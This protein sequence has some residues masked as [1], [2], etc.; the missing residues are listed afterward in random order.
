M[1]TRRHEVSAPDRSV[2]GGVAVVVLVAVLAGTGCSSGDDTASGTSTTTT[3]PSSPSDL[4]APTS[5]DEAAA[6]LADVERRLR[7]DDTPDDE[8]PA[9]GWTQ[10]AAYRTVLDHPGWAATVVE[11]VPDDLALVVLAN[12]RAGEQLGDLGAPQPSL[13]DWRISAPRPPATLLG[14]YRDAEARSGIPW[15]YLAAIHLVESRMGRIQGTS[16]AGAQ[17]PMQFIP[18]TWEAYG[19]G[20]DITDD[21]DAIL[22]AG[23]YL[24]ASGG[25]D[26]MGAALHAYNPSDAYV[27]AVDAYAQVMLAAEDAYAGY[28]AWQVYFETE[29]GS[30]LLPEGYDGNTGASPSTT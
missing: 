29:D 20:G 15:A 13:P 24:A 25:P 26:D 19:Q 17:G 21:H 23:R 28:H 10:Q 8:L 11:A 22:A 5:A 7:D 14:Y 18:S 3:L 30:V 16:T 1:P 12:L 6:V 27:G 2:L 9:S 4:E